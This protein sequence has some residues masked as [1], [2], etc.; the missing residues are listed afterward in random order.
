MNAGLLQICWLV[1]TSGPLKIF[2]YCP[3][4]SKLETPQKKREGCTRIKIACWQ[5]T[6]AF[7]LLGLTCTFCWMT[8][9]TINCFHRLSECFA[10]KILNGFWLMINR[11]CGIHGLLNSNPSGNSKML[12]AAFSHPYQQRIRE[13]LNQ[14]NIWADVLQWQ[15]W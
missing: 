13:K 6:R 1:P 9:H 11:R 8:V 3:L 12:Q 5:A 15:Q 4:T 10:D 7:H 14:E 2:L